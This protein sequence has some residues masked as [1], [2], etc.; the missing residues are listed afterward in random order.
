MEPTL[1]V[2]YEC[3]TGEGPLWHPE[4]ELLYWV[5]IPGGDLFSYDPASGDAERV[6]D[7]DGAIG[8][9]TLED[10][11]ALL[12]FLDRGTIRP[13]RRDSGLGSPV[14]ESVAGEADSRFNDVV[15]D[16][17]GRV[18]CG[19]M[20]T[21]DHL[22]TLYRLDTDGSLSTVLTGL[23]VPNGLGFTPD[24]QAMYVTESEAGTVYRFA[25]D[26]ATGT[27]S[28][29]ETFLDAEAEAGIPDGLTVDSEGHVWSAFWDGGALLRYDP[30][31]RVVARVEFP[32]RKVSSVTF[33]G[34]DYADV[35]VTTALGSTAEESVATAREREG[36]GAGALFGLA[37]GVR[38]VPEFR[39]RVL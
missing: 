38:G 24:R 31:G 30:A 21:A 4:H 29:R 19:T 13:W 8:G 20:P 3:E 10:S 34:P 25:Y 11:G 14:V 7:Y 17:R 2:D 1:L 23:D 5:D 27:L 6:L 16:P 22:G 35:Y 9:F 15:A 18:F 36:T 33:G 37:P 28:D 26:Q 12:L 39:S 32:A